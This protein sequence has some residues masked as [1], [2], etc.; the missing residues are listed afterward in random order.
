MNFSPAKWFRSLGIHF[1]GAKS[2]LVAALKYYQRAYSLAESVGYPTLVGI[3]SL[4][5]ICNILIT[6]G[7]PLNALTHAKQAHRHAEHM[8]D[9]YL[10]AWS[11]WLQGRCHMQ[12]ANYWHAQILLQNASHILATV[13]QQQSRLE[14]AILSHQAE[15]HLVKSE[16]LDSRKLQVAIVSSCQPTSYDAIMANLN[17]ASI[18]IATGTKSKNIHQTL[19]MAQSH[20]KVLYGFRAKQTSLMADYVTAQLCL[21]EG[22]L[23]TANQMFGKC[24]ASSRDIDSD[25]VLLCLERLG[26]ISTRMNDIQ[27][28]MQWTGIFLGLALK[29]K[30]KNHTM[31]A[32]RCLGQFFSTQGDDETALSLYMVALEGFTFSD[33]HRWRADCMVRIGNILNNRG[34]VMEAVKLWKKGRHLFERSSQMKDIIEIDTKLAEVDSAILVEYEEQ[35]QRLSELHVPIRVPEEAYIIEEDEEDEGGDIQDKERLGVLV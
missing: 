18:D 27:T 6:T 12:L 11:V 1:W 28:T 31:Q 26:E 4:T 32:F 30:D 29:C 21:R 22:A 5:S 7:K 14:L 16:Y 23:G 13:G 9:M 2:D 3:I 8:G 33:V 17:I 35:L 19:D 15:I 24:L 20:S 25:L 34:E 10:Q